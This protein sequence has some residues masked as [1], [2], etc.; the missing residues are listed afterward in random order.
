MKDLKIHNFGLRY[1]EAP[2]V[3]S[4]ELYRLSKLIVTLPFIPRKRVVELSAET[5]KKVPRG[6]IIENRRESELVDRSRMWR[7][8]FKR[9]KVHVIEVDAKA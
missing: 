6:A 5:I 2:M 1:H 7:R 3:M 9:N 8:D 4:F